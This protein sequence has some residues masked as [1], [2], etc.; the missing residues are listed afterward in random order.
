MREEAKDSGVLLLI[1]HEF[2][3][4][5]RRTWRLGK[6]GSLSHTRKYPEL[7]EN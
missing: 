7:Y 5:A 3:R 2:E 6:V 4:H 1:T